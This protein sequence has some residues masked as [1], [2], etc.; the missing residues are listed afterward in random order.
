MALR[1]GTDIPPDPLP[2]LLAAARNVIREA[3]RAEARRRTLVAEV[4][5]WLLAAETSG[6]DVAEGV[7]S[8]AQLLAAFTGLS[9]ADQDLLLLVA[10]HG[11]TPG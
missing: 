9:E 11:L 5:R 4:Q 6:D 1:R 10:W 7:V 3:D 2:W 8:R